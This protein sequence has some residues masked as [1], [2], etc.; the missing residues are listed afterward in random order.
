VV[1]NL[2][3][4]TV[5]AA[6]TVAL[7]PLLYAVAGDRVLVPL[8]HAKDWLVANSAAVMAVVITI[9]G[10]ALLIKGVEGL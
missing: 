5:I 6:S 8:G 1:I 2:V 4:F 9:I 7:P 3:L 10:V